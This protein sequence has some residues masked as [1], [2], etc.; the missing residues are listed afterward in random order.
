MTHW[1]CRSM[2]RLSPFRGPGGAPTRQHHSNR[3]HPVQ[4]V[5]RIVD[6]I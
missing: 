5:H 3:F 6:L 1:R 2:G 4:A